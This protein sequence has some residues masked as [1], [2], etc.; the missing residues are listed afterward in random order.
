MTCKLHWK[1][2]SLTATPHPSLCLLMSTSLL[3]L[4]HLRCGNPLPMPPNNSVLPIYYLTFFIPYHNSCTNTSFSKKLIQYS[5]HKKVNNV[6]CSSRGSWLACLYKYSNELW[7]GTKSRGGS[8]GG[9]GSHGP[10]NGNIS[11]CAN[12][13]LAWTRQLWLPSKSSAQ[14]PPMQRITIFIK[15]TIEDNTYLTTTKSNNYNTATNNNSIWYLRV[16]RTNLFFWMLV[17]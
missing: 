5:L 10:P 12:K 3:T 4:Y 2:C 15:I 1:G 11:N 6:R 8:S 9:A 16:Q 7:F 17:Q 13:L 14:D